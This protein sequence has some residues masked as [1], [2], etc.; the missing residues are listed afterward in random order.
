MSFRLLAGAAQLNRGALGCADGAP[1]REVLA[2]LDRSLIE[3]ARIALTAEDIETILANE[4]AALPFTPISLA[5]VHD[6]DLERAVAIVKALEPGPTVDTPRQARIRRFSWVIL[7]ILLALLTWV[8][9][10]SF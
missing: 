4:N 10:I 7:L 2:T 6:E 8:C 9:G 5:V 3:S 1:V